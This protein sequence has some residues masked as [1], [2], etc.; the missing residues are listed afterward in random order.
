MTT[1]EL[2]KNSAEAIK[3]RPISTLRKAVIKNI[4]TIKTH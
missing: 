4:S 3:I 2:S 1:L